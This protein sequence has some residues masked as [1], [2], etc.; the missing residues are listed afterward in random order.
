[1]RG[2]RVFLKRDRFREAL[3]EIGAQENSRVLAIDGDRGTGKTYSREFLNFIREN[4]P[5][6]AGRDQRIIFID[7]D[8]CAFDPERLAEVIGFRLGL[9]KKTM[10]SDTGEQ[11]PRRVPALI[12]WLTDGIQRSAVELW[13]IILDGFRV[14]VHPKSTHDLIRALIDATDRDWDRARLLLINYEKF[15]DMDVLVHILSE[16][17]QPIERRDIENF[18][19]RVYDMSG[20]SWDAS[21]ISE[22]VDEVLTQVEAQVKGSG[23]ATRLSILSTGLTNA[24]KGLLR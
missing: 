4:D 7:M 16:K 10:P 20:K 1:M 15:L 22:T 18:F 8:D 13:W 19:K 14:Q 12:E 9:D 23:S 2:R 5:T 11:A 21:T 6:W 3:Q 24:A 17:I